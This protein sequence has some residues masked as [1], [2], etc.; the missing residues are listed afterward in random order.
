MVLLRRHPN[1]PLFAFFAAL[2]VTFSF[3]S[4]RFNSA[5]NVENILS[6]YSF[7]AILAVGESLPILTR[8]IDLSIGSNVA[9]AGMV[10]YDGSVIL[11][12]PGALVVAAA[13]LAATLAGV[14]N[15]LLVTRL[16]LQPFVATLATLAG[17][18]GAVYAISGRQ[19]FPELA[20]R[21]IADP[22]V[23]A[24]D[25]DL[26]LGRLTH[27]EGVVNLPF[28]PLSFFLMLAVLVAAQLALSRTRLGLDLKAVGGNPE[29]ARLAGIK[30]DR[31]VVVAY[32]ASGFCAGLAAVILVARLT[33]STEAL[34]T[35]MELAAVAAAVIGGVSLQGGVGNAVGPC[36]GAFLLGVILIG[37][38]LAGSSQYVQQVITG[39]ILI[40][41]VWYDRVL[42]SR[43]QRKA[44]RLREVAHATA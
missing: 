39:A 11:G 32:A 13:L 6:N 33:T 40:A 22:F 44:E 30:V 41:A 19:L 28:L 17:Y 31:V 21:A 1:V 2:Y 37:L 27:L 12:L 26:D 5:T 18:R 29:A 7:M 36:V 16:R 9:L 4:P 8:G 35:G 20:T 42:S 14:V 3:L 25:S 43:R 34:G 15:G 23:R 10:V 38:T 24:F